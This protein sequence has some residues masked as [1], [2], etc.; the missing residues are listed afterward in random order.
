M[1]KWKVC[2]LVMASALTGCAS[3]IGNKVDLSDVTFEVGKTNKDTVASTLGLPSNI[4]QSDALG[5]EYW[6][7]R[8]K[9]ELAG[10]M[11]ALPT[12]GGAV[13]SF[14]T[15]TG[16]D[17]SYDFEDAAVVYIFDQNGTMIDVR[18]P[19]HK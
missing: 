18:H 1:K 12:G 3:T 19:E 6:A 2:L 17:G 9:P 10:V 4:S 8:E 13:T 7:Y 15:S 5:L 16:N 11:Y 14:T